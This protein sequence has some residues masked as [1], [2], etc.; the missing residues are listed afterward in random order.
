MLELGRMRTDAGNIGQISTGV[1][2]CKI[3]ICLPAT[4]ML[5]YY[6]QFMISCFLLVRRFTAFKRICQKWMGRK[7]VIPLYTRG[8]H[9]HSHNAHEEMK[10]LSRISKTL[11]LKWRKLIFQCFVLSN[12]MHCQLVWH[13]CSKQNNGK[14]EKIP[15]TGTEDTIWWLRVWKQRTSW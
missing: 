10:M 12:F 4:T 15:R 8:F 11:D 1:F 6:P 3:G 13:F 5:T 7:Y 2:P 14:I 9:N